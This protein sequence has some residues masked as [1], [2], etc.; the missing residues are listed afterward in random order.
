MI[1]TNVVRRALLAGGAALTILAF[2]SACAATSGTDHGSTMPMA[3][4]SAGAGFNDADA[5]FAQMMIP[6]HQQAV[7]MATLADTR[8]SDAEIKKIAAQ[9]KAAQTPEITTMTG[10]L[11]SRGMPTR[12]AGGHNMPGMGG[13]P[14]VASEA[15]MA[16][17]KASTGVDFDRMFARM[18]IAH[19]NGAIQMCRDIKSSGSSGEVQTFAT[20]IEQAQSA[21]VAN[22]QAI[23]DRL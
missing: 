13:M 15:E 16:Q 10:W 14:G 22:L 9:I 1:R 6:H 4:S 23:L 21:E 19:H 12:Q 3:T 2:A 5:A 20:T 8:A 18:M 7:E 11:T 17:L